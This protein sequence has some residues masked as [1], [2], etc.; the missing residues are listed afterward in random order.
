M[1]KPYD[2]AGKELLHSDPAAWAALLGIDCP[3]DRI[4]L[5]DTDLS[6]VSSAADKAILFKEERP[7]VMNVEFLSW[8]DRQAPRQ[9]LAYNA[10]LQR[11]H[12]LPVASVLVL[13]APKAL[14]GDFSGELDV[15]TPFGPEWSF[16][17]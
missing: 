5:I 7:W 14:H 3:A 9:L 12:E 15:P 11:R 13:L 16:R 6:T 10:L 4:Q 1:S 2:A 8:P 17:Y